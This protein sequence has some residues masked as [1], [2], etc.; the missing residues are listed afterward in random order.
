MAI[1]RIGPECSL[2]DVANIVRLTCLHSQSVLHRN[3]QP[4]TSLSIRWCCLI[5][6]FGLSKG[7]WFDATQTIRSGPRDTYEDPRRRLTGVR[8][9]YQE[10]CLERWDN[11]SG[12][13]PH[14]KRGPGFQCLM[15]KAPLV[16]QN[17]RPLRSS[18]SSRNGTIDW[19]E[20]DQQVH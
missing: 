18:V 4:E 17:I 16:N 19:D 7:L 6:D 10:R 8:R 15:E 3:F 20:S 1:K 13:Q 12:G 9:D 14:D 2:T 11:I 5:C